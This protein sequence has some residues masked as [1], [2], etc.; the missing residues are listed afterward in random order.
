MEIINCL[1]LLGILLIILSI[2][3]FQF[4]TI[5]LVDA[6]LFGILTIFLG[7][8]LLTGILLTELFLFGFALFI[9]YS[10]LKAALKN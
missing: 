10:V 9:I 3:D 1:F 5:L 6:I 8:V 4:V 2:I 7:G